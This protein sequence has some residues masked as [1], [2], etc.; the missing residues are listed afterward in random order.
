M[1]GDSPNDVQV[2]LNSAVPVIAV[3]YGYRRI[4]AEEMGAD[5]LI[6]H[7]NQVP[8]ALRQLGHAPA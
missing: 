2:A 5:I 3:A 1:I 6:K 8:D 4:P 7:F